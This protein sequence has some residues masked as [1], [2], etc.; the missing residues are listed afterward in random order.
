MARRVSAGGVCTCV[1]AL[2]LHGVWVVPFGDL[3]HVRGRNVATR[4]SAGSHHAC[5]RYGRAPREVYPLDDVATALQYAVR[6]LNEE[7]IVAACDSVLHQGLLEFTDLQALFSS[8]PVRSGDS[9]TGAL[10]VST[11]GPSPSSDSA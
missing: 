3:V 9:S 5:T 7:G 4:G 8:M 10:T 6:C 2:D 1:S 11:P